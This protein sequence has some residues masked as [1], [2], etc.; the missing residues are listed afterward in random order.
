M[1]TILTILLSIFH[2]S[3][4]FFT[5]H[6]SRLVRTRRVVV[7]QIRKC[8]NRLPKPALVIRRSLGNVVCRVL[9][10]RLGQHLPELLRGKMRSQ[11]LL[12]QEYQQWE[13]LD[14][15]V[16]CDLLQ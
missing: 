16:L 3:C 11:V 4:V 7:V 12:V 15:R 13:T 14:P 8:F 10:K 1:H 2:L 6:A 9:G 5:S